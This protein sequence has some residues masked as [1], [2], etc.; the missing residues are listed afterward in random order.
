MCRNEIEEVFVMSKAKQRGVEKERFWRKMIGEAARSGVSIR[1]FC[2]AR[3]LKESQLYWWRRVLKDRRHERA[4]RR[5]SKGGAKS[6]S[7]QAS[8]VLVSEDG[9]AMEAGIELVL[10]DGCRVRIGKGVDEETLRTVLAAVERK[11]C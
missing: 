3:K 1:E 11:R 4:L 10:G 8:F 9:S 2:R 5:H 6:G 7:N